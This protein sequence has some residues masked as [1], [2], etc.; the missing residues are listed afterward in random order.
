M[1]LIVSASP[2]GVF[3]KISTTHYTNTPLRVDSCELALHRAD[4]LLNRS[5]LPAPDRGSRTRPTTEVLRSRS[6][7]VS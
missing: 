5:M 7:R 3:F 4:M 2:A 1:L 6:H